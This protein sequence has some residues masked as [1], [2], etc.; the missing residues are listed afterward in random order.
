MGRETTTP[1]RVAWLL[2]EQGGRCPECGLYFRSDDRMEVDHVHPRAHQG[3]GA[4]QNL[5]LLHRHCHDRK[6]AR[7]KGSA[8]DKRHAIEEPCDS[9]DTSTVLKPSRRGDP[10]A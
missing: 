1:R 2:R 8:H 6:T 7:D 3:T 10:P 4:R 9:K 5:Q